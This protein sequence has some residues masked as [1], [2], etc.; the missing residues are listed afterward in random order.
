MK[1]YIPKR[2]VKTRS[3]LKRRFPFT[4]G[5]GYTSMLACVCARARAHAHALGEERPKSSPRAAKSASSH[6]IFSKSEFSKKRAPRGP[7]HDFE[8]QVVPRWL[9]ERPIGVRV[10]ARACTCT[11]S[12]P[13]AAKEQP[14]SGQERPKSVLF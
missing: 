7:Q 9:Q 5:S 1:T 8:G 13:R 12:W 10:C 4:A 11:R 2:F 14:K 6:H 3:V